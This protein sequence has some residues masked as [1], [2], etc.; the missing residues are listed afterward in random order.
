MEND[1]RRIVNSKFDDLAQKAKKKA[2]FQLL[3]RTARTTRHVMIS[4]Q[5]KTVGSSMCS[6]RSST[7]RGA[8]AQV[9]P[10]NPCLRH[11]HHI[12]SHQQEPPQ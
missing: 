12:L 5:W 8:G 10:H 7:D 1:V 11:T 2:Y 9:H 6:S 4:T 3:I